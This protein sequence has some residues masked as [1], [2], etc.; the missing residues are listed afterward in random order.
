MPECVESRRR[1]DATHASGKTCF[2]ENLEQT[3][4]AGPIRMGAAAELERG[5]NGEHPD[6]VPVLLLEDA[7]RTARLGLVHRKRLG[8]DLGVLEHASVDE[9]F[10]LLDL[11][12][13]ERA[14]PTVVEAKAGRTDERAL[15]SHGVTD[16]L[17]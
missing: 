15:L 2:G 9:I 10:D 6:D 11:L 7:D 12:G 4:V 17:T 1:L 13:F 14:D 8:R 5:A 3:D 16:D